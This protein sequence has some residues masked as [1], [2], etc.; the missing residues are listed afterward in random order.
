MPYLSSVEFSEGEPSEA[1]WGET[2][3]RYGLFHW[4]HCL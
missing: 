1:H 2:N 3:A 4:D